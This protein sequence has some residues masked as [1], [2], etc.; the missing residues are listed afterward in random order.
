MNKS[1]ETNRAKYDQGCIEKTV[2]LT[3]LKI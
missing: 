2:L 3:F 1:I